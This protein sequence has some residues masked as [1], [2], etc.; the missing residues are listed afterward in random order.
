MFNFRKIDLVEFVII[1]IKLDVANERVRNAMSA[2]W[3]ANGI[4]LHL[5]RVAN[6]VSLGI[7]H[8]GGEG[9]YPYE[10]TIHYTS[11]DEES[12]FEE[13]RAARNIVN[14][15]REE[16]YMAIT[17]ANNTRKIFSAKL[18][19]L[20]KCEKELRKCLTTEK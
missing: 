17:K 9:L 12:A 5:N 2:S 16:E 19:E 7:S 14:K 6:N 4:L 20:K 11:S 18:R 15:A 10:E 1:T 3:K 8:R 13:C